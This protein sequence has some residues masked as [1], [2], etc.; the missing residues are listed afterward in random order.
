MKKKVTYKTFYI[1]LTYLIT[2]S[3]Y[4]QNVLM[5]LKSNI[6]SQTIGPKK[7]IKQ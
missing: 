5:S 7:Y 6:M 2:I 3:F 4:I 1:R